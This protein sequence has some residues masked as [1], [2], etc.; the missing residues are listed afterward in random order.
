MADTPEARRYNRIKRWL[1][2]ADAVI[3]FALL[4]VLLTTGWTARLR[5]WSYHLGASALLL[6]RLS[7]CADVLAHHESPQRATRF[8]RLPR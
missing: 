6:R 7:L 8:L 2:M 1:G 4:V 3:G 5:D